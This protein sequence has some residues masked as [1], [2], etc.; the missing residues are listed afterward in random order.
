[1][2]DAQKF[3][4][5]VLGRDGF[6][7]MQKASAKYDGMAK[8]LLP[9]AILAWL[10]ATLESVY[11][12]NLPGLPDSYIKLHK[13]EKGFGGVITIEDEVY[14]FQDVS[15]Y[16][17]ASAIALT[18]GHEHTL[19]SSVK[20]VDIVRLGKS[21]DA[22]A[23]HQKLL[24]TLQDNLE[25]R[26]LDPGLGYQFSHEHTDLGNGKMMTKVNVHS[27]TGDHVAAATFVH[28][29]NNIVPGS[30]VVDE[31]HQRR[32]IASAMYA[33]AEKHTGKSIMPSANQTP[34]GSALWTGN[35]ATPQFGATLKTELP[36]T[37]AAAKKPD[38]PLQPE[39]PTKQKGQP[40]KPKKP[41]LPKLAQPDTKIPQVPSVKLPSLKLS[42]AQAAKK[43]QLCQI[44]QFSDNK[45]VG[46]HCFS[47]L[48]KSIGA[49][50]TAYGY[51]VSFGED[52][53]LETAAVFIR[54]FSIRGNE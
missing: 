24:K 22:L 17:V 29:G 41:V 30:V 48:N 13:A 12:G 53:D 7:V 9:R 11:E 25:K 43:C 19:D 37:A 42:E 28:Q 51:K 27:P 39:Q 15:L 31:D 50:K 49:A 34:E 33:H 21:I 45:F 10:D 18:V 23:K 14:S 3:L 26:V 5:S 16:H 20:D 54:S 35:K 36:G 6:E 38:E 2:N 44:P 46:C 40:P 32:G 4:T 8:I 52:I 47:A 1:M